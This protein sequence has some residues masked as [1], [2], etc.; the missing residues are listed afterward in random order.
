MGLFWEVTR[1][2]VVRV[3]GVCRAGSGVGRDGGGCLSLGESSG[4]N[5]TGIF[6]SH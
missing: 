4:K 1:R 2:R 6:G 5:S 3:R